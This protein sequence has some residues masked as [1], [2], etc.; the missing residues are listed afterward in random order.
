MLLQL[1]VVLLCIVLLQLFWHGAERVIVGRGARRKMT[2]GK[3]NCVGAGP[4]ELCGRGAGKKCV[5]DHEAKRIVGV[6]PR[7]VIGREWPKRII[8]CWASDQREND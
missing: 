3:L 8:N 5:S 1:I 7:I 2:A 4:K 6:E